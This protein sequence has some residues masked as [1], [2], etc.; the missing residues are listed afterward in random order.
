M[1]FEQYRQGIIDEDQLGLLPVFYWVSA[2]V[3]MLVSLYFLIYVAL[4]FAFVYL[5]ET[6]TTAATPAP[7]GWMFVG[8]GFVGFAVLMA[9]G[10]LK[11]MCGFWV[12]KR[13]HRIA[14]MVVAAISCLEVPYG[15]LVGVFTFLV[16]ARPSVAARFDAVA[17]APGPESVERTP[18]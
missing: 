17:A 3:T 1:E 14:V 6:S 9:I 13:T 12:R 18:A 11:L 2:G 5:P 4:G 8:I 15:T 16:L 7:V 10:V